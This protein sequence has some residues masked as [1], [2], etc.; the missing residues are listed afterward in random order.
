MTTIAQWL[1]RATTSL[2]KAGIDS[3]KLDA[4]I[5]L[6]H[7]L[8]KGR[9]YLHA[10]R[11]EPVPLRELDIADARLELR[12]ERTPIAY[13]IGHK[14]FYGRRFR[15]TPA[16]LIPRPDSEII[17]D[18]L[19]QRLPKMTL[20][21]SGES[22][23]LVD[24]GTGSGILGITAKLEFPELEVTLTD[25]SKYAL[26]IAKFNAEKLGADVTIL[27]SDLLTYYP[28]D[29]TFIL[30][31]LPYVDPAW[32]RSP[33][34]AYE[35]ESALFAKDHGLYLIKNLIQQAINRLLPHGL[36]IL[37]ADPRQ[38]NAIKNSA[39]EHGFTKIETHEFIVTLER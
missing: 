20:P 35:P 3:A 9:T 15:V 32:E 33:E 16:T 17:I 21:L 26:N 8:R 7:T 27:Q 38:H 10:Y 11:D 30:A 13:I 37:E 36:L 12:L 5:I 1:T 19:K 4:E 24:I 23:R 39:K 22:L 14:E 6:A 31:N 2:K 18:V 25:I 34:T 28:Y 29:A